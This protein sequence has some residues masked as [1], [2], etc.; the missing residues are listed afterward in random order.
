MASLKACSKP[1]KDYITLLKD[2]N[3]G[4][5]VFRTFPMDD[6]QPFV[7]IF[8]LRKDIFALQMNNSNLLLAYNG[9]L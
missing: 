9:L 3:A 2:I 6:I 8:S 4:E 7:T 5:K 1:L